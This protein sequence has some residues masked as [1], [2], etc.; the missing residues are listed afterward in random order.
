MLLAMWCRSTS[1]K[2]DARKLTPFEAT[3]TTALKA[4]RLRHKDSRRTA[5]SGQTLGTV[6]VGLKV[7]F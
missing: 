4:D 6:N 5:R 1:A 3:L 7:Q 2:L